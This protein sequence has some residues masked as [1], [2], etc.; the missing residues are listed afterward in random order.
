MNTTEHRPLGSNIDHLQGISADL[1]PAGRPTLESLEAGL[2]TLAHS[3]GREHAQRVRRCMNGI[4][5]AAQASATP[6]PS[7]ASMVGSLLDSSSLEQVDA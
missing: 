6:L 1:L 4:I 2:M 7:T 3:L 5:T